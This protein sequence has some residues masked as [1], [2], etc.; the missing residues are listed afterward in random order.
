VSVIHNVYKT[1]VKQLPYKIQKPS[2]SS[3]LTVNIEYKR[4]YILLFDCHSIVS[5]A[6]RN[7]ALT[8]AQ[9]SRKRLHAERD[10][11]FALP[12]C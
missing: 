2:F 4:E 7:L 11:K 8:K 6:K 9:I 1:S 12:P 10:I 5:H 3:T